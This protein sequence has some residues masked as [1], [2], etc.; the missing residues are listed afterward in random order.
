MTVLLLLI[1][2]LLN[3]RASGFSLA[4]LCPCFFCRCINFLFLVILILLLISFKV[5][6]MSVENYVFENPVFFVFLFLE[7]I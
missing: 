5:F 2:F 1:G 3:L 7:I 6:F 4:L